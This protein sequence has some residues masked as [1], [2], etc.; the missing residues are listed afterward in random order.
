[1]RIPAIVIAML[2]LGGKSGADLVREGRRELGLE[3]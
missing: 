3:D 2:D 1:M